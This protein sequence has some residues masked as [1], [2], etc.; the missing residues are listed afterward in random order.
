MLISLDLCLSILYLRLTKV[1]GT[2]CHFKF[3]G[4]IAGRRKG[5]DFC[6]STQYP[7]ALLYAPAF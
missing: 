2:V 1:N 7:T 6:I 5:A 3:R 4:S